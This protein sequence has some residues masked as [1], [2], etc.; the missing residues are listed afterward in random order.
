MQFAASIKVY[1][2][3]E[4]KNTNFFLL[5][6]V[7]HHCP[8]T[9][10]TTEMMYS[11]GRINHNINNWH[12]RIVAKIRLEVLL[13]ED[14]GI[15]APVQNRAAYIK[16]NVLARPYTGK[17]WQPPGLESSLGNEF[18]FYHSQTPCPYPNRIP[19]SVTIFCTC[20]TLSS[21]QAHPRGVRTLFFF[22]ISPFR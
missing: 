16:L 3:L 5:F 4:S 11:L 20:Q 2:T 10:Q 22:T 7:V 17:F 12:H 8:I 18:T 21:M 6:S 15:W 9:I 14:F 1:P 13:E 19:P